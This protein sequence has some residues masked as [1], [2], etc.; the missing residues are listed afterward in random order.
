[1]KTIL[2]L[3]VAA[4]AACGVDGEPMRPQA[5]GTVSLGNDGLRSSGALSATN[6]TFTI[7]V[8]L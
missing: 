6:G 5:S 7:G 3:A 2:F 1:M 4:L 8:G